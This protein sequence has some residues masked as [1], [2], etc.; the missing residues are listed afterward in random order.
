MRSAWFGK[1]VPQEAGRLFKVTMLC[2]ETPKKAAM[3]R[4]V[5]PSLTKYVTGVGLGSGVYVN[6]GG[7]DVGD[8]VGVS[9]TVTVAVEVG[10]MMISGFCCRAT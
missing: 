3:P 5:S 10:G 7:G 8:N 4:H 1:R 9:V 2:T 6:V